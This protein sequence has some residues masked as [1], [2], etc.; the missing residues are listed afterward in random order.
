MLMSMAQR[1][2]WPSPETLD[3]LFL[4]HYAGLIARAQQLVGRDRHPAEDLVHDVYVRLALRHLDVGTIENIEAYLFTTL[5]NVHL[6]PSSDVDGRRDR[7]DHRLRVRRFWSADSHKRGRAPGGDNRHRSGGA[8]LQW[9]HAFGRQTLTALAAYRTF[10]QRFH[11]GTYAWLTPL[12]EGDV[13]GTTGL[14]QYSTEMRIASPAGDRVDYVAGLFLL[15]DNVATALNDPYPGLLVV[16]T[17]NRTQRNYINTVD[18][19]NYAT[20]AESDAR[21]TDHLTVTGGLRWTHETVDVDITGHPIDPASRRA[22]PALGNTRDSAT[23]SNV[24]WRVGG[25]WRFDEDRMF[26]ASVATGF[27]GPGFNVNITAHGDAQPVTPETSTSVE[28]GMKSLLLNRRLTVNL[29]V[30]RSLFKDFQTQAGLIV[31]GSPNPTV[32]LLNAGQLLTQGFEAEVAAALSRSTQV[33]MNA[34][35]IDGT[36]NEFKDAPC[37][38]GQTQITNTC[39]GNVQDLSGTR[40]PNSP[41]WAVNMFARHDFA[42]PGLAQRGFV[43]SDYSWRDSVQWNNLGSPQGIEP[44]YGLLGA[45]L[46]VRSAN[47]RISVKLYA[48]NL[49]DQFYTSGIAVATA[50]THFLPPDYRRT[51]G[52]ELSVNYR[53]ARVQ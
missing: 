11:Q 40:L 22:G 8:Q 28:A 25:Q 41:R 33:G 45:S 6:S 3:D 23:A 38:P 15:S 10:S 48:K 49:T 34:T 39:L 30:Y 24:S 26:Y 31:A 50:V 32:R 43:T 37:Y 20:F 18:T 17:T 7:V 47:D 46:G 14:D 35:F 5:R 9:E 36:F 53:R 12:D 4:K 2:R 29:S 19:L 13:M 42:V 27:K 1:R 51:V 16:G 44:G 52:V 21:V